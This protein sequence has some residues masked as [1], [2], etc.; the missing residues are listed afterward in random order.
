MKAKKR[1]YSNSAMKLVVLLK[2]DY[3]LSPQQKES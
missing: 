1:K 2:L 3:L